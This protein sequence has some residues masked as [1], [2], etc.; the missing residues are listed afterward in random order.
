MYSVA[1]GAGLGAKQQQEVVKLRKSLF[2][3]PG[4]CACAS[5]HDRESD[6]REYLVCLTC[7][8]YMCALYVCLIC[9]YTYR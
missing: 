8:P 1:L 3:A 4:V 6:D 7:A 9:R 2:D 5:V